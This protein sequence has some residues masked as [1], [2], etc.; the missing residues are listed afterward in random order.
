MNDVQQDY[1]KLGFTADQIEEI[2]AG[3]QAD[4]DISIYA[5]PEFLAI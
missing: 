1:E 2:E 4:V 5:K 3:R